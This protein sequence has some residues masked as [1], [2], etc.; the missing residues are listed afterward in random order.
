MS[1]FI[2]QNKG[3]VLINEFDNKEDRLNIKQ[4]TGYLPEKNPMYE[5]MYVYEYLKYIASIHKIKNKE[6]I[7]KETSELLKLKKESHKKI[8]F[9]S[10]GYKQRV[11]LAQ[12]ILHDPEILLLD[13]PTSGLDPNQLIE[14]RKIITNNHKNRITIISTH[15]LQ[16]VEKI[17]TRCIIIDKGKI[18]K[19]I[20][21]KK[22]NNNLESIFSKID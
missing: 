17:C 20:K 21:L 4:I 3:D 13:E 16:E 11:G 2:K 8:K 5:Y 6:K 14:I 22:S 19:D 7:I 12:A 15:I 18:T 9:L 1:C 10:K